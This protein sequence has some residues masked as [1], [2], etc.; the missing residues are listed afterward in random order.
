MDYVNNVMHPA[1]ADTSNSTGNNPNGTSAFDVYTD[2]VTGTVPVE[3]M[4]IRI[5]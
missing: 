1:W 4:N 5:E 3:L 2:R